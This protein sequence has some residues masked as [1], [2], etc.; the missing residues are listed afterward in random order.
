[1]LYDGY[2]NTMGMIEE[3][4]KH[5]GH[6]MSAGFSGLMTHVI[7]KGTK[8]PKRDVSWSENLA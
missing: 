6:N 4:E 5:E 1:M 8:K 3:L 7:P 2:E